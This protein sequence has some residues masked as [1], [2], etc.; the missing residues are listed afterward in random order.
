V[1]FWQPEGIGFSQL[2]VIDAAGRSARSTVRLS[3]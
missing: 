3:P 1:T 2:T